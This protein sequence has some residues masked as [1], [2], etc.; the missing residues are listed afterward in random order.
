MKYKLLIIAFVG[1][2]SIQANAQ[3]RALNSKDS[4]NLF[5]DSD[6]SSEPKVNQ[7]DSTKS[8]NIKFF[9]AYDF[10]EAAFN[11][12]KSLG[13]E[14]G[15]RFKND[16]L[17]RLAYTNLHLSEKHLSSD[18]AKAVEGKHV[19]G[20]Q[21][22]YEVFYDFPVFVK[23]LYFSPSIG[24]YTH[25]Y[26]HTQLDEQLKNSS[27]TFGSAISYTETDLFK[28]KGLYYR[29]SIPF[30]FS[31]DPIE[32]TKLGGTTIKSNIFENNI[33]FFVGYQF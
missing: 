28:V 16:H 27:F 21:V 5:I 10:G 8:N 6:Y 9:I 25:E 17:L 7:E 1:L 31:I 2:Y 22:G 18:F 20:K 11:K 29:L 4:Q 23:G 13:S 3:D 33:W 24:Y 19:I 32:E 26:Q 30:R 15:I 12:F 14:I